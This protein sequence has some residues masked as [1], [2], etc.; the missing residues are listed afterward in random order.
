L[1]ILN[2]L[3]IYQAIR[4]LANEFIIELWN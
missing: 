3:L 1:I 4:S 2:E